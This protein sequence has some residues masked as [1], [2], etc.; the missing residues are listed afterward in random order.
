MRVAALYDI[1]GNLPA[2][3]AV[4][5]DVSLAAPDALIIGGDVAS[6]PMPR[7]TLER[8]ASLGLRTKFVRG[9]ADRE[10]VACYDKATATGQQPSSDDVWSRRDAW[11][12]QQLSREHRDFLAALPTTM[13][14]DVDGLGPVVFCHG[15]PR[16]D[17]EIITRLTPNERLRE[18]LADVDER[19]VVGGHTH[20]QF[21]RLVDNTRIVNAGS[22][23]MA[24][25]EKAAAY[26]ALLGPD[27]SLQRTDYDIEKA[28]GQILASG[29]PEADEFVKETLLSPPDPTETSEFF[30]RAAS[31]TIADS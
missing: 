14:V 26:W 23:G 6:G 2:L 7:E 11:A 8:L 10:L 31:R 25:E 18:I 1:H 19:V 27:V 9:N 24:Y 21:D 3:S 28:A 17:E 5:E 22:V 30:E 4:L 20:V 16:S 13:V 15:S 29:F 12:A